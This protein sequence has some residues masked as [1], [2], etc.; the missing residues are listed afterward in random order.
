MQPRLAMEQYLGTHV[1]DAL[2]QRQ[3]Q[4]GDTNTVE[5]HH[6]CPSLGQCLAQAHAQPRTQQA[7]QVPPFER[8]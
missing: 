7:P 6:F 1:R 2:Q 5:Q 8:T 4:P 3:H